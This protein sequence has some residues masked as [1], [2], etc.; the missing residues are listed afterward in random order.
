MIM[1]TANAPARATRILTIPFRYPPRPPSLMMKFAG[2][3]SP[4]GAK[5][6]YI[7]GGV[8]NVGHGAGRADEPPI[9]TAAA[10]AA[11]GNIIREYKN[12]P[13]ANKINKL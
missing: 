6:Q 13:V 8:E 4:I 1:M 2:T 10:K 12:T 3:K 7:C 11:V 9:G 5:V